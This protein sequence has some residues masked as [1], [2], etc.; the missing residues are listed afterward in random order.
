MERLIEVTDASLVGSRL[1]VRVDDLLIVDAVGGRVA[2]GEAVAELLGPLMRSVVGTHGQ[3]VTPTG[4]P[5]VLVVRAVHPGAAQLEL[6]FGTPSGPRV[7]TV[8]LDV[9]G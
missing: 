2:S 7:R 1:A 8:V 6:A 9:G 5:N 3:V 4:G